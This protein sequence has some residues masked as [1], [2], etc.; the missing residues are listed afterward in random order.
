VPMKL[1][2]KPGEHRLFGTGNFAVQDKLIP[3]AI[4][5]LDLFFLL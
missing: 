5:P 4:F 3:W 1:V 2:V